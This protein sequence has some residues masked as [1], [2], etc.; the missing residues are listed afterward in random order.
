MFGNVF[1]KFYHPHIFF[2]YQALLRI[3]TKDDRI[4]SIDFATICLFYTQ[5]NINKCWFTYTIFT[6]NTNPVAFFKSIIKP[7]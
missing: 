1:Y 7:F 4:A 2:H 5:E 3:I 6:N